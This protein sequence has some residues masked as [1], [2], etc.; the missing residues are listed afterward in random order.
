MPQVSNFNLSATVDPTVPYI[1]NFNQTNQV[2]S[3]L[4]NCNGSISD[5]GITGG[6]PP[7]TIYWE[8]PSAFT[9]TTLTLDDLCAGIYSATTS[10]SVGTS[11]MEYIEIMNLSAGTFS[12]S[13][14]DKSCLY[15][16]SNYCKIRVHSFN[17]EQDKFTYILYKDG[18]LLDTY[19]STTGNEI[20]D[21]INLEPGNYALTLYDG[22]SIGYSSIVPSN[23]A[24]LDGYTLDSNNYGQVINTYTGLSAVHI[25]EDFR[26]S[27]LQNDFTIAFGNGLGPHPNFTPV[28]PT[29][30]IYFETGLKPDG[31]VES[32]DPYVWFYTGATADRKTDNN[33]DWYLGELDLPMLD[34][35]QT[36]PAG[37]VGAGDIG[38]FYFNTSINKFV[39]RMYETSAVAD[40]WCTVL[41]TTNRGDTYFPVANDRLTGSTY[42]TTASA[43]PI[44]QIGFTVT[45][46]TFDSCKWDTLTSPSN[47]IFK[48]TGNVGANLITYSPCSYLNYTHQLSIG[49][50][51]SDDD[52]IG[53]VLTSFVDTLGI[54]GAIG[55]PQFLSLNFNNTATLSN[56]SIGINA[57]GNSAFSFI[58]PNRRVVNCGNDTITGCMTQGGVGDISG[59]TASILSRPIANSPFAT[60]FYRNQGTSFV[61]VTRQGPLGE[62]FRIQMTDLSLSSTVGTSLLFNKDYEINFNLLDKN[63]WV[64]E[65][66][67]AKDD[68]WVDPNALHKFLGSQQVGYQQGSQTETCFY[69]IGFTGTQ[70]N[71]ISTTSKFGGS[72]TQLFPLYNKDLDGV[73]MS[74][75]KGLEFYSSIG[76]GAQVGKPT[77]PKIQPKPTLL[78]QTTEIPLLN[79]IGGTKINAP[80]SQYTIYEEKD[81][82]PQPEY[83]NSDLRDP[84]IQA[85]CLEFTF[86]WDKN[87]TGIIDG[88]MVPYYSVHPYSP[89]NRRFISGPLNLRVFDND[90]NIKYVMNKTNQV[91]GEG[92][93]ATDCLDF[94]PPISNCEFLV[95]PNYI[96]KNK[97][98]NLETNSCQVIPPLTGETTGY[99]PSERWYDTFENNPDIVFKGGDDSTGSFAWDQDGK[100]IVREYG[101]YDPET[102]F[103][104][105]T[106]PQV[107]KPDLQTSDIIYGTPNE[108]GKLSTQQQIVVSGYTTG[109]TATPLLIEGIPYTMVLELPAGGTPQV[110]LNGLTLFASQE[111]DFSD[112]GDYYF[113]GTQLITFRL[114]II[115]PE[116]LINV[117]YVPGSYE[118]SYYF[119][120]YVVPS[121]IPNISGGTS[122]VTSVGVSTLY[123]NGYYYYFRMSYEPIGDI[124]L[125]LN[126]T[127]LTPNSDYKLISRDTVQFTGILYP[128]GLQE[129]DVISQFYFTRITLQGTSGT[130][131]PQVVVAINGV[132][133]YKDSLL[134]VVRNTAG[135]IIYTETQKCEL[136]DYGSLQKIFTISVPQPGNYTYNVVRTVNYVLINGDEVS[137]SETSDTYKFNIPAAIFYDSTGYE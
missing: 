10:D 18:N 22:V 20:H 83:L 96:F 70:S 15:N 55:T 76:G 66:Y 2:S 115:E 112:G 64:G 87:V 132:Y 11:T 122:G 91:I 101:L 119:D 133:G 68:D 56:V 108:C 131:N 58:D 14:I 100:E 106:T 102:D 74:Q 41:A 50:S 62:H 21:F 54:Y 37:L 103:Y 110:V 49:S 135:T 34:G 36:G 134:L 24:C 51:G 33:S 82:T 7:Y 8:G 42:Y 17:H 124:G 43:A 117:I 104:F 95:K 38:K 23:P 88:N 93:E 86:K 13:T 73:Q 109:T 123:T 85:P 72:Q 84:Q 35:Q 92:L 105:I 121:T 111:E 79:F 28:P 26:K 136:T 75:T 3:I 107:G 63:T 39:V 5:V 25:L 128:S 80:T 16:I 30:T 32:N 1:Y 57:L 40:S 6:T 118:R 60:G 59:W 98:D 53:L 125:V 94:T 44:L 89:E 114:G 129:N 29:S 67:S 48:V 47:S 126:G 99:T 90:R 127:I 19:Q 77:V 116:D 52:T 137:N 65:T 4:N 46:S 45:G 113:N 71:Y 61:R 120:N 27:N 78:M 12:A 69:N 81:Y 130:K 97:L 9:A 31:T